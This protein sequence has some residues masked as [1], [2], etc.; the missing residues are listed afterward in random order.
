MV[1]TSQQ[2]SCNTRPGLELVSGPRLPLAS[3]AILPDYAQSLTAISLIRGI[4]PIFP[5][6]LLF[7]FVINGRARYV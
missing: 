7:S 1:H 4:V 5:I 3:N 6:G 2:H